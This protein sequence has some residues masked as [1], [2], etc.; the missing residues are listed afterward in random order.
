[1]TISQTTSDKLQERVRL[2]ERTE[3]P[4]HPMAI[5]MGTAHL[6]SD[7]WRE[8]ERLQMCINEQRKNYEASGIALA[9][10][11]S[12]IERLRRKHNNDNI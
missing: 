11:L 2:F 10:A 5:H 4:E 7:L 9:A 6:V 8:I 12:E 1:M 3:V